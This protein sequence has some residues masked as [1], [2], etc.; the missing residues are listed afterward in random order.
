MTTAGRSQVLDSAHTAHSHPVVQR[1]W[2]EYRHVCD[3]VPLARIPEDSQMFSEFT[4]VRV[5]A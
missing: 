3:Y 2:E 1:V 4:P 5:E